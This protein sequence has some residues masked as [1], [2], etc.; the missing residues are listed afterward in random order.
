MES[1]RGMPEFADSDP[2]AVDALQSEL[3]LLEHKIRT[4]GFSADVLAAIG[5][6]SSILS[7]LGQTDM[8]HLGKGAPAPRWGAVIGGQEYST[9]GHAPPHIKLKR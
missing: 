6:L 4:E 3:E 7:S 2:D 5:A 9:C 1:L 8:C